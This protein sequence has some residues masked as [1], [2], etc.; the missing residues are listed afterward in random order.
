MA[1]VCARQAESAQ[2]VPERSDA[3]RS[4]RG[5]AGKRLPAMQT[6]YRPLIKR[7]GS[8]MQKHMRLRIGA[9]IM[10]ASTRGVMR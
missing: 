5:A 4:A 7:G 3:K 8:P 1:A 9:A 10:Q 2:Q 6:E